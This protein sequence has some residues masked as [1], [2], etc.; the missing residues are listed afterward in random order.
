VEMALY[1]V[2]CPSQRPLAKPRKCYFVALR[3]RDCV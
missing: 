1:R 2:V 3:A